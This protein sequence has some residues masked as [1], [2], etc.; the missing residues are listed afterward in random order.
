LSTPSSPSSPPLRVTFRRLL[1]YL[2]PYR[3]QLIVSMV[4]ATA[5]QGF[6]LMIPAF[7]GSIID[8]ALPTHDTR[9][10]W[11]YVTL[12]VIAGIAKAIL[13]VAR[14][15]LAG[16]TA[17]DVEY[18]LRMA[19][20]GHI[21]RLSWSFYDRTQTGQLM[22]RATSDI[23]AV[24]FFLGYG[25]I[26]LTQHTVTVVTVTALLFWT[27]AQLAAVTCLIAPLIIV[28]AARYSRRSH[29]ILKQAQQKVADVTTHAEENIVGVRVVKAFA[30]EDRET[31]RFAARS[32]AVFDQQLAAT[33]LQAVYRPLLE[34]V[35][36]L[37]LGLIILLGG[38]L[39]INGQLSAGGFFQFNLYLGLLV[40][41]LRMLGM[42]IGQVQRAIASGE[43]IFEVL[44]I[45]PEIVE[46]ESARELP[47]EGRGEIRLEHVT[48]GYDASRPVLR[49]L[50]LVI[51]AG[52]TV[53]LIGRTGSGKTTLTS[54]V[55][56]F[57]DVD[58]GR[59]L[60]D[61]VDVRDLR[62]EGLR[63][64]V[65]IVGE[66]TF[67][68]STTVREN[69]AYGAPWA[70][71]E[72]VVEAARRAQAHDFIEALPSGYATIV[73]ER[74]LTLSG[75]Q[76]QRIAIARA[77]LLDPRI[78]VLDD[79]TASVDA[80]TEAKIKLALRTVMK[81]RTTIIIAHRLSTIALADEIV[82][83]DSGRVAARGVHDDLIGTSPIY[84]E[85]WRHGL[86]DRT[87]VD[88]DGDRVVER[89][90]TGS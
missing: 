35:P 60:V 47:A 23:Q 37:A 43:R 65:G 29:P 21:Q 44:D 7:V 36:T 24:R 25:L 14:R 70:T 84:A 85:I 58:D 39:V 66:E 52:T 12:I 61:G 90:Q 5:A 59:V 49:D 32:E 56:R 11:I 81:G 74:G 26:F 6:G 87:F 75:G 20:Y 33:R 19:M 27:N 3:W 51:E 13:M 78:L 40:F 48:F 10:L 62:L 63:R 4:L 69:I 38:L 64:Q 88:L 30:Q 15:M 45:E 8:N 55:P 50:D 82:V 76:R 86:V 89:E 54:L 73:G 17:I 72:D 80:T 18:D 77:L 34:F 83:I 1:G 46:P 2:R 42:W 57:Y 71:D 16:K 31:E 22:S 67:L 68:F 53:A 41:P 79:A 9:T 28:I